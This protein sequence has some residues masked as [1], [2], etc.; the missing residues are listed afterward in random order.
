MTEQSTT[1]YSDLVQTTAPTQKIQD[2]VETLLPYVNVHAIAE[3]E[4]CSKVEFHHNESK[5]LKE[6][7]KEIWKEF[8]ENII[9]TTTMIPNAKFLS[10]GVRLLV[11][12]GDWSKLYDLVEKDDWIVLIPVV[13]SGSAEATLYDY[14]TERNTMVVLEPKTEVI[15][16]GRC[17]MWLAPQSKV[18][19]VVLCLGTGNKGTSN[20]GTSNKGTSN[21]GTSKTT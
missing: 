6:I 5:V 20:K 7:L 2:F 19:C 17:S 15:I 3:K 18:V 10:K 12:Q 8:Q 11:F 13:I 21:K 9:R 16:A 1:D 14:T 4:G